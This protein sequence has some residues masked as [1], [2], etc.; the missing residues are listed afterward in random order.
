MQEKFD[1]I[2]L[3]GQSNASGCGLGETT[4]PWNIDQRIY[5]LQGE[6]SADVAKTEYGNEYLDIKIFDKK[7]ITLADERLDV[8]G[9]KMASF[10]LSFA[11]EYADKYLSKDRKL[12]I[13]DT[14]IGGTGFSKNHWGGGDILYNRAFDLVD[15]A[16]SLNEEHK[17]VAVLWHQ[18]EHD[19]FENAQLNPTER[20]DFYEKKFG[21]FMKG[22][23][24][25]YGVVP[26]VCAGFTKVWV[27]SYPEQCKAVLTAMNKVLNDFE[28]TAF[29]NQTDDLLNNDAVLGNS[30]VVH[31]C[32]D[33][34]YELGR[35]YFIEFEKILKK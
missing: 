29:V 16:L 2:I 19:T 5:K 17:L 21:D 7:T 12:L 15:Y 11:K 18:G 30:D 31:F 20:Y 26:F 6:Y 23:R 4:T 14:A 1:I 28:K 32:R 27:E 33:S 13:V 9:Q 3:A 22:L 25:K 8:S 24:E 34:S 35:R 10:S